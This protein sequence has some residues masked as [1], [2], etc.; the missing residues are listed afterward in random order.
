MNFIIRIII[1]TLAVLLTSYLLP[2]TMV[3][4]DGFVDA[5][6][7]AVVLAFLNAVVKPVMVFLTI[8]ATMFTFG[9]FLLVINAFI[10]IIADYFIDGFKVYGFWSA[11]LFS[12]ILSLVN[13]IF[14]G[15]RRRDEM[16]NND[17]E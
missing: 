8:P 5:L 14:E 12:V 17:F 6:I 4:V 2:K 16:R 3:A 15:I 13:S 7:V 9:L 11:L 10:I 1:S